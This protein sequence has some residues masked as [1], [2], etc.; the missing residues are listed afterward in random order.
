MTNDLIS[1]TI[2]LTPKQDR[3][4]QRLSEKLSLDN[5]NVLR[6]ALAKLVEAEGI[7]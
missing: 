3:Q 1:R 6:L 2:R 5:T 4:L 7:K